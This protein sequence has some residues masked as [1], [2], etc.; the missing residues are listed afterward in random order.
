METTTVSTPPPPVQTGDMVEN[1]MNSHGVLVA[2]LFALGLLACGVCLMA[3]ALRDWN[4]LYAPDEAYHAKWSLG[5]ASRYLGRGPARV[6][7][8][9][10]GV[11]I[12]AIGGYL[13]Y[14]FLLEYKG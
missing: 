2:R 9:I 10:A 12:A 3:G 7:G 11:L 8:F 4:W 13:S 14:L 5:Q 1:W 6:L